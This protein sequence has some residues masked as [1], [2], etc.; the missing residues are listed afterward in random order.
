MWNQTLNKHPEYMSQYKQ[1]AALLVA[2]LI[3]RPVLVWAGRHNPLT[4]A[5]T[6]PSI[7]LDPSTFTSGQELVF[8]V[9]HNVNLH[10]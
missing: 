3:M 1:F 2:T 4:V 6:M 8:Q 7:P 5:S 9:A 10:S